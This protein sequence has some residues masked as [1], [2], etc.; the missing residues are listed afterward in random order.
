MP[1]TQLEH[2][3]IEIQVRSHG[4]ED[5]RALLHQ[6]GQ[7]LVDVRDRKGVVRAVALDRA[8]G[9]RPCAVPGLAQRVVLAHEQQIFGLRTARH[10]HRDGIRLGK[11]AQIVEMA[12][13]AVGV[14]DIAVAVAHRGRRQNR[15][16]VLAD[17]AH[18]LAPAARE[19]LAIHAGS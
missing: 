8:V 15:D 19:L 6:S 2:A 14:L 3:G 13:L 17:H 10:Q 16:R 7:N 1:L 9:S 12:V 5:L 11:A 4:V 18:E